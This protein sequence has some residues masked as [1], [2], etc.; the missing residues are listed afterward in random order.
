MQPE[1]LPY[2]IRSFMRQSLILASASPRRKE[3]L[4]R[5]G[6]SVR[7][8]P[9]NID[10]SVLPDEAPENYVKRV[11][12]DKVLAVVE[13]IRANLY[14]TDFV[15]EGVS[16]LLPGEGMRWVVGA[17]TIVV[18]DGQIF[19]KPSDQDE[20]LEM[21]TR[22]SGTEHQVITGFC[23][24]DI[25]KNK[26]GIQA[27]ASTVKFKNA[28]RAEL[29]AYLSS[30]ESMDKAGGYAIQGVGSYLVE[31]IHGS[32]TN[33]VGLPLCQVVEMMQ[34]LGAEDVLPF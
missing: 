2:R 29:E 18:Y 34:E 5:I 10:E 11:S 13:R 25:V 9:A 20:A 6:F 8:M 26:E 33:V 4:E 14:P 21:L 17:D 30:G 7:E 12:R 3:L 22:L 16:R 28:S 1:I 24:F 19:G 15:S 23:L 31:H 27:V 32:Y